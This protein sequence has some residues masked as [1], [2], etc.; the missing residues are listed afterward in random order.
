MDLS[1]PK[2]YTIY[3]AEPDGFQCA[4]EVAGCY[5]ECQGRILLLERAPG[6]PQARTWGVPAGKLEPG[7]QPIDG[8]IRETAEETGLTLSPRAI[9]TIGKLY[10]RY[11]ET[12]FIYYMFR[13]KY[14]SVPP[15]TLAAD[16]ATTHRWLTP[17]QARDLPLI[18]GGT[19]ALDAYERH[20]SS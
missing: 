10:V 7:E 15:V 16:E 12:D 2:T 19:E 18:A 4:V 3:E 11:P 5:V 9:K 13:Y 1:T 8:V 20:S 14:L 17:L 6:K